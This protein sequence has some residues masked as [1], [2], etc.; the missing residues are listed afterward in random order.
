MNHR[1]DLLYTILAIVILSFT[2]KTVYYIVR[3]EFIPSLPVIKGKWSAVQS[4]YE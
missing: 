3:R 1:M 4:L 2:M